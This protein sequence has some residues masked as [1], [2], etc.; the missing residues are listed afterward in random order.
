MIEAHIGGKHNGE[1]T[2]FSNDA[3][4]FGAILDISRNDLT[5]KIVVRSMDE[6]TSILGEEAFMEN[7][8]SEEESIGYYHLKTIA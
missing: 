1:K 5:Q 3:E 8:Q 2:T 4:E 7:V 6:D